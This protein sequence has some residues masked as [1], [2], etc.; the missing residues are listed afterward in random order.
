M[1]RLLDADGVGQFLN[2]PR[3]QV[4]VLAREGMIPSVRLG[5]RLRFSP[6]ALASWVANGGAPLRQ[7]RQDKT[8][9]EAP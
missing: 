7:D 5:R 6:A 4:Y 3:A 1:D 2:V 8:A 9:T